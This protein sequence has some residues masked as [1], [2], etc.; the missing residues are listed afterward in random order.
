MW[1]GEEVE[2]IFCEVLPSRKQLY[3]EL[4]VGDDTRKSVTGRLSINSI[5]Y[6][7]KWQNLRG[8]SE[9]RMS[10]SARMHARYH[11]MCTCRVHHI[12]K[13]CTF[14]GPI[15]PLSV[16]SGSSQGFIPCLGYY[17]VAWP[18]RESNPRPLAWEVWR[19]NRQATTSPTCQSASRSPTHILSFFIQKLA[20]V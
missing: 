13:C 7:T 16:Q 10:R 12:S 2:D 6:K 9:G 15:D 19:L 11:D 17:C 1:G 20:C 5:T 4:H 14:C 18:E 8:D 3:L